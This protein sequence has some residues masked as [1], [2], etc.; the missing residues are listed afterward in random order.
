M[1]TQNVS[2]SPVLEGMVGSSISD[3][4]AHQWDACNTTDHPFTCHDFLSILEE[5]KCV[6][7]D[8]GWQPQHLILKDTAGAVVAAMPLYL[9]THSYGEY[10]FDHSWAAAYERAGGQYYPKLLSAVPFSPVTGPR[11]LISPSLD[12]ATG[13]QALNQLAITLLEKQNLSSLHIN[14]IQTEDVKI[15]AEQSYLIRNDQQFHWENNQYTDFDAFL[16]TLASRKRKQ[17]RK[18]RKTAQEQ[19]SIRH[20]TGHEITSD[21]WDI[22]FSFYMDTGLRKWGRPYLN[23]EFF[24]CLG[25]SMKDKCLLVLAEDASGDTVAGAL[26]IIGPDTLYGRYWGCSRQIDCL[27]FEICYYQAIDFAIK[28]GLKRVEAGAQGL[29]KLARGYQPVK[30]YSAHYL[31]NAGFRAAVDHYLEM[32]RRDVSLEIETLKDHSPFKKGD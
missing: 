17:L 11:F 27:H 22:F 23:R 2:N 6:S 15:L 29:H 3:I 31:P 25:Q 26:N 5:T 20:L 12:N 19:V 13:Q 4:P 7:A 10:V 8:Q 30:T 18:E 24:R 14:F 16:A 32:E 21:H 1:K 28:H 9:K